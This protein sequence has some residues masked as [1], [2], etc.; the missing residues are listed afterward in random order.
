MLIDKHEY[1]FSKD[2]LQDEYLNHNFI[3]NIIIVENKILDNF[4]K[5][6]QKHEEQKS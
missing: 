2:E 5:S 6:M 3:K 4:S 1:S